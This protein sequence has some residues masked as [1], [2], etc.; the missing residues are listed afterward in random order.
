VLGRSAAEL[1]GTELGLA[2]RPGQPVRAQVVH[3]ESGVSAGHAEPGP[4]RLFDVCRLQ[5]SELEF[6][7]FAH[8]WAGKPVTVCALRD[9]STQVGDEQRQ[10]DVIRIDEP[11]Y[12]TTASLQEACSDIAV[13]LGRLTRFNRFEAAVRMTGSPWS[14]VMFELGVRAVGHEV[15]SAVKPSASPRE[16]ASWAYAESAADTGPQVSVAVGHLSPGVYG[17][18]D[19]ATLSRCAASLALALARARATPVFATPPQIIERN[20]REIAAAIHEA[21]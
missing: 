13:R 1:I 11:L 4:A 21:A 17:P 10:L 18:R 14:R 2:L 5:L 20:I 7:P 16:F 6:W 9:I 12:L 3:E 15:S 8:Q 19:A